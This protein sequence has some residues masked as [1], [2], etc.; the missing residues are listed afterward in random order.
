MDASCHRLIASALAWF[1]T[2]T[3]AIVALN[4]RPFISYMPWQKIQNFFSQELL[5][6][7][8]FTTS[9]WSWDSNPLIVL[10][11]SDFLRFNFS[12]PLPHMLRT[13]SGFRS[14]TRRFSIMREW[15][16]SIKTRPASHLQVTAFNKVINGI[17]FSPV[18]LT[19]RIRWSTTTKMRRFPKN[20]YI[21]VP[22]SFP[23]LLPPISP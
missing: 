10:R 13:L 19:I 16:S 8:C 12:Q 15:E 11:L 17:L 14:S 23:K 20:T 18:L 2:F 1:R 6:R 22:R 9:K 3:Q 5:I 4:V 21:S 7:S